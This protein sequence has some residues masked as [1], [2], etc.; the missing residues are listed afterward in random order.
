MNAQN[1]LS[2][3]AHGHQLPPVSVIL[4]VAN[5]AAHLESA[6]NAILDS[7]YKGEIEV[8]I[9]VGPSNDGTFEIAENLSASD[10]RIK[11]IKNPSGRTPDGLNAAIGATQHEIIVRVDGHSE[12]SNDYIDKAVKILQETSAVNVG[13]IMAAEGITPFQRA[14]A[15]AMRSPVGV[16]PARFHTGGSAGST[17]TVYLGVFKRSALD[18]IGGYDKRFTR[19]Q[20]WELNYRLRS[21]GG[22]IWFD[23]S[24]QVTYRP[25]KNPR[26]L[27][28]Q[29]FQYGRWR[30]AVLR[31]H[32]K[33]ANARYLA[34]PLNLIAQ[35]ISV[36][37]GVFVNPIFFLLPMIYLSAILIAS[38]IL[39]K[40]WNEK[41]RLPIV[42]IIM[43][44][45]WGFGF[46]TS[47]RAL[48]S[49]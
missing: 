38:L 5:E 9:A 45:C 33:A 46:I 6:I 30:S 15:R 18:A 1:S 14:V 43:H 28:S 17:D 31:H 35:L 29:Y 34:P 20:D 48:I 7:Q 40:G 16:G 36:T 4:T 27:A 39:G 42:L 10:D 19:A 12:I 32:K 24:L 37:L 11:V 47:P 8:A 22:L 3:S 25:R 44:F 13:G 26:A 21:N 41:I 23:P 49:R 2:E